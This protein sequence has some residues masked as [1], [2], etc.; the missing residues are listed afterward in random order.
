MLP[1]EGITVVS[2][3][4]AVAVPFATRQLADLGARVIKIE[5]VGTGDFA[6]HYDTTVNGMSSH[7]VWCN[8]SKESLALNLKS[9][10]SKQILD[11]LLSEAD[12]F[13]Q[14]LAPGAIERMGY[15]S[16]RLKG[17]YPQLI[18]CNLSGYG[19]TGPYRD[20]KAYDLLV[21]CEAGL[22]SVTGT[23]EEPSK[24]G[25]SAADIA[26]GMYMYSGILTALFTRMRTGKGTVLEV[27]MLEAL[28]EWMG[29]PAYYAAYGGQEPKRT[30]AS[31]STI[32]PY[33]PFQCGDGKTVFIGLQNEREWVRFCETV[34][35]QPQLKEDPRFV[36]N[37]NRSENR[38][39]LKAI[40][41]NEFRNQRADE[42]IERLEQAQIA[43]ARMNTMKD[44]FEH[45][46]LKAR[47]RWVEVGSPKGPIRALRPPVTAEG[48]DVV[49]GDIPDL[50]EHTEKILHELGFTD[51]DVNRLRDQGVI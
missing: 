38:K 6:R 30:G 45:P 18:I 2:I 32:Y 46:Q 28:G 43:N 15:D 21:Q 41:E 36:S 4:Q 9:E 31:H 13:V 19:S 22:V 48:I 51:A 7:F 44:F 20:K 25:I 39:V 17:K 35:E 26:A 42:I 47:N 29:Y 23:E 24:A 8:R 27:S 49:M 33:G 12:V 10:A 34:L 37:A 16:E 11:Q 50:G 40:I 5:R 3:E 1:L 14:N